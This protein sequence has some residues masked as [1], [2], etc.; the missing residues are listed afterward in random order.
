VSEGGPVSRDSMVSLREVTAE[1]VRAICSLAVKPEQ[2]HLVAP[3]AESIA[4]AYFEP[5]AWFRAIYAD[6]TPAGFVMLYDDPDTPSYHLWRFMID[7][8]YQKFGF[9]LRA[10][11]LIIAHVR[12][13]PGAR[14]LRLHY[15][16]D[17]GSARGL[18]VRFGFQDTG[19][20]SHGQNEMMLRLDG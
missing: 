4:E 8:R 18:Y 20:V 12:T 11:E 1:T 10:L 3:N 17:D 2:A 14:E 9:G 16:P 15:V 13:R 5:R 6:E 7:G 19:E